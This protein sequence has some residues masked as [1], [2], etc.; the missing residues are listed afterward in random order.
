[1]PAATLSP[2]PSLSPLSQDESEILALVAAVRR[3]HRHRDPEG[4][5]APF[6]PHAVTYDLEPP[7]SHDGISV[8]RK[9][10]WLAAWDSPIASRPLTS[11]TGFILISEGYAQTP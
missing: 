9:R 6:A 2:T 11:Q 7:L 5:A 3:A 4:I 8:E 10:K 1:M